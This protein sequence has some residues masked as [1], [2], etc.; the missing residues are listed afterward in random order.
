MK[1]FLIGLIT[2]LILWKNV[3]TYKNNYELRY[4]ESAKTLG[5]TLKKYILTVGLAEP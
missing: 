2:H 3:N 4:I 1:T 5:N